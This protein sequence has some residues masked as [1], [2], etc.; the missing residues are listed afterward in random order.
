MKAKSIESQHLRQ[1]RAKLIQREQDGQRFFLGF[2]Y[3]LEKGAPTPHL[4]IKISKSGRIAAIALEQ[5]GLTVWREVLCSAQT[6]VRRSINTSDAEHSMKALR[7]AAATV[8]E[9]AE[10]IPPETQWVITKQTT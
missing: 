7:A 4:A 9:A 2:S 6:G 3:M 5:Q 10:A 1:Q 8:R